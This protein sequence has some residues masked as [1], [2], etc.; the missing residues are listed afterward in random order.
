MDS[1]REVKRAHRKLRQV[2]KLQRAL[3]RTA[4]QDQKKRFYSL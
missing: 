3:Y 2:R 4:K 1:K